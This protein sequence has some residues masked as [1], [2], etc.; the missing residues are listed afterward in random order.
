MRS[1]LF[2]CMLFCSA[3]SAVADSH[4]F[5]VANEP[6]GYGVDHCL[7]NG[8]KCG[9]YAAQAYCQSRDFSQATAYRRV[10][11]ADVTGSLPISNGPTCRDGACDAEY[12]A[13]TCER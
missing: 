12:V 4:V 13:I 10:A 2:A 11:P 5:I 1:V 3:T 8:E 9:S 7:A 6:D